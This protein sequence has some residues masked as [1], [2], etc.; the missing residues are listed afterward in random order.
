MSFAE[1]TASSPSAVIARLER[2]LREMWAPRPG[3]PTKA[4]ACTMNLV[5]VTEAPAL[6]A[7]YTSVIDEVTRSIPARAIVVGL[8]PDSPAV[9]LDGD[10]TAVC[11][12]EG[13]NVVCSER[14]NLTARGKIC[15]RVVSAIDALRVPEMPTT[16]VWLGRWRAEAKAFT[17]LAEGAQRIVIDSSHSGL[18]SLFALARWSKDKVHV[19][20]LAWT[21]LAVWQEMAARFF[22][23]PRLREHASHVRGVTIHQAS[24]PGAP[25]GAEG[26]LFLGWLAT[27]LGWTAL[28]ADRKRPFTRADGAA[29]E[30]GIRATGVGGGAALAG[31]VL[32]AEKDG[33]LLQGSAVREDETVAWR[34]DV[35]GGRPREQRV[36]LR[37]RDEAR[38]LE[39]TLHRG[40]SDAALAETIALIEAWGAADLAAEAAQPLRVVIG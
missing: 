12:L 17:E 3:E 21:R 27:R 34:L 11:A 37:A 40:P 1:R 18:P 26:A 19:A 31:V 6:A 33:L 2:E 30:I 36:P 25:L 28:G 32:E 39:R 22:D 23:S 35:T 29:V 7:A 20:D 13:K 38:N 14:L 10:A 9:T 4:R 24:E 8:D 15:G 16:I 5:V